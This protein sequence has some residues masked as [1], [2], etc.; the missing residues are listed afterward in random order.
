MQGGGTVDAPIDR[1]PKDRKK[2]AIVAGG[3][4]AVT[5][6]TVKMQFR[7]YSFLSLQ[8][9]TGRTHQIRVH[10]QHIQHPI[11]GDPVYG[12]RKKFPVNLS[13]QMLHAYRIGFIHPVSDEE[14][15]FEIALPED[16]QKALDFLESKL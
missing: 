9:Q 10:M 8:L 16:F 13:R 14:M 4:E 7:E 5:H 1:H 11:I 15:G 12:S 6:W 2:M 3:K